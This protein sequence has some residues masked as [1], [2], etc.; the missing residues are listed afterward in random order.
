M[1][2][3]GHDKHDCQGCHDSVHE[4]IEWE[5]KAH[6]SNTHE[7]DELGKHIKIVDR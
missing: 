4:V 1:L 5:D 6:E 7:K 3:A 2:V